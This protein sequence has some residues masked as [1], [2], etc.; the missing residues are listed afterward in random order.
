LPRTMKRLGL[1]VM[2]TVLCLLQGLY[3]ADPKD[4]YRRI[5]RD[6]DLHKKRLENVQKKE[7]SVI[8]ELRKVQSEL[9]EIEGQLSNQRKKIQGIQQKIIK[10]Q[11]EI[12]T[13]SASLEREQNLLKRRLRAIQRHDAERDLALIIL[14]GADVV[15]SVRAMKY[16]REISAYD[17]RLILAYKGSL[18]TLSVQQLELK[19]LHEELQAEEKKLTK[20]EEAATEKKKEREQLLVSVRKEKKAYEKM[21]AELQDASNRLLK[22]IQEAERRERELRQKK[23]AQ[24]RPGQKDEPEEDTDFARYKGKLPWPVHGSVAMQYGS[25]VD[26]IFNLPVFRSGIHI[27]TAHGAAIKAVHDGKVVYASE[28]KGYGHLVILSHG[29]GYHSL[30]GNLSKITVK[31]G[32]DV[33]EQQVIGEAGESNTIGA[34]GL[35]F[36]IR[37]KGKPLDPQQWLR[38]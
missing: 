10:V 4:E 27:K 23:K 3:A 35:Y 19:R 38:R 5:Q 11:Q 24:S 9:A 14:S 12:K 32:A 31:N 34:S 16:L 2:L 20:M 26:P 17:H 1:C 30:Y 37:Y 25:Q 7:Q 33:K 29:G 8:N 28:F 15:Q 22:L 6:L 18:K 36:E 21:V 13:Y